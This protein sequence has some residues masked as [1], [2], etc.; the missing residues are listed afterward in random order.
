MAENQDPVSFGNV[1]AAALPE[2]FQSLDTGENAFAKAAVKD[3]KAEINKG[4]K[5][6]IENGKEMCQNFSKTII[7]GNKSGSGKLVF[8]FYEKFVEIWGESPTVS[9]LTFGT[10]T[11]MLL[12]Q[13]HQCNG[14]FNI[15]GL[16]QTFH[17]QKSRHSIQIDIIFPDY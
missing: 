14:D 9:K 6:I 11:R 2:D 17:N 1:K 16:P 13:K 3:S 4:T 8:E 12:T 15:T 10:S 7:K 5:R